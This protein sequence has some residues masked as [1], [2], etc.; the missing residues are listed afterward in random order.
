MMVRAIGWEVKDTRDEWLQVEFFLPVPTQ[1]RFGGQSIGVHALVL[2]GGRL[3]SC[4]G[5]LRK[6]IPEAYRKGKD[7]EE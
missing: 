1:D 4:S 3:V 6:V 2:K 7:K 5:E